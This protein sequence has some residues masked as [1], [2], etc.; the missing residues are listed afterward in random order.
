MMT[1]QDFIKMAKAFAKRRPLA[2]KEKREQWEE[3][4][5]TFC[6]IFSDNNHAFDKQ[7]FIE[8]TEK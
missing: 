4:R 3:L 7:R 6:E 5:E 2:N 1:K 8:A